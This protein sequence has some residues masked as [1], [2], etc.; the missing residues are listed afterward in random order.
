MIT[1]Q[2]KTIVMSE[3]EMA[4]IRDSAVVL[5]DLYNSLNDD[6]G[7]KIYDAY[8]E[9]EFVTA[10]YAFLCDLRIHN[11]LRVTRE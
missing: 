6:E 4:I 3:K 8:Y 10:V 2:T 1:E 11:N 5:D 7:I 9:K